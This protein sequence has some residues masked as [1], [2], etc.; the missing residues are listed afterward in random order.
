MGLH[1]RPSRP[2]LDR[3]LFVSPL[4]WPTLQ[5]SLIIAVASTA[6]VALVGV[7]FAFVMARRNFLGKSAVEVLVTFPLVLPPMVVGF[8]LLVLLGRHGWLGAALAKISGGYSVLLRPEGAIIAAAVVSFPLLYLPAKSA[9]GAVDREMEDMARL[10][11]ANLLQIFWHISIPLARRG[12]ASG[13]LL[14]F[15]RSL[16]EFGATVMVLGIYPHRQTLPISIYLDWI[17][18]QMS[19]A[20]A[21]VWALTGISLVVILLYNRSPWMGRE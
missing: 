3:D 4:L 14:T 16:G 12:I 17:D 5:F 10:M 8:F 9:F 15:A 18:G 11:G 7:P 21:A 2:P 1:F 6:L 20:A 19:H 13:L